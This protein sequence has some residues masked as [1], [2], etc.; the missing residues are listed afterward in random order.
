MKLHN[1]SSTANCIDLL[2]ALLFEWCCS[3]YKFLE[4]LPSFF[5]ERT[6]GGNKYSYNTV[7]FPPGQPVH[8]IYNE[9]FFLSSLIRQSIW[10]T[11]FHKL[12]SVISYIIMNIQFLHSC[13]NTKKYSGMWEWNMVTYSACCNYMNKISKKKKKKK[14]HTTWLWP[15]I[16]IHSP[17][18]PCVSKSEVSSNSKQFKTNKPK[19]PN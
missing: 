13:P 16:Y 12:N 6:R 15:C 2:I 4:K 7:H 14:K 1:P 8:H 3:T 19:V 10:I 18:W 5:S 11:F 9:F 17:E